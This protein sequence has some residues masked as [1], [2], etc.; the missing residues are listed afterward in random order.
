MF[1]RRMFWL[2]AGAAIG[3]SSVVGCGAAGD[4]G[5]VK[6]KVTL[7]G[8]PLTGAAVSFALTTAPS[9]RSEGLFVG[10]TDDQGRFAL[11]PANPKTVGTPAGKYLVSITTTYVEGGTPDYQQP[12]P[13]RVPPKYRKGIDFEVPGSGTKD[14]NFDLTS[15]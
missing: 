8:K 6:G 4:S 9:G 3:T 1:S 14:A 5:S 7:D 15:K 12:P 13:E 2:F 10:V 11:R